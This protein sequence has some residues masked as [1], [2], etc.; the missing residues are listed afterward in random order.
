MAWT[1]T[2]FFITHDYYISV[3][4]PASLL[5]YCPLIVHAVWLVRGR[6]NCSGHVVET[7][8]SN[9]VLLPPPLPH[10]VG[11]EVWETSCHFKVLTQPRR[12]LTG[13]SIFAGSVKTLLMC[14]TLHTRS[15]F[16]LH[17]CCS[18]SSRYVP[19]RAIAAPCL[20]CVESSDY[21]NALLNIHC[22]T[23][24]IFIIFIMV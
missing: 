19:G 15:A 2:T 9:I 3:V 23:F 14:F 13:V 17:S 6:I 5:H 1:F 8:S 22:V 7:L 11:L 21:N 20:T 10:I 16:L 12:P 4:L 18:Y 24:I